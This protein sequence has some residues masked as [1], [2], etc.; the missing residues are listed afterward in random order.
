L[1]KAIKKLPIPKAVMLGNHDHGHDG[2]GIL[3]KA[4][5]NLL[6]ELNCAWQFQKWQNPDFS[7]V[8]AR[9]CSSGGG[10]YISREVQ[11]VF[12]PISL[13]QS[14]DRIVSSAREVSKILPFII[15]A[16]SGPA[17]LG[18]DSSSPCGR[19][20]KS[21]AIDWG[22]KDL[23]IAIDH[24]RKIKV[25]DL[26]VFGHTHHQL[27]R[28]QGK[29]VTFLKDIW[30]TAYLNAACVPRRGTTLKGESLCHFSWVEFKFNKLTHVSHRWYRKNSSLAYQEILLDD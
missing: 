1:V 22:D 21:P 23:S 4:Q 25:P 17:G 24:I 30:G 10:F 26:V 14:V 16:H 20:W 3:L 27:K 13:E 29:R 19:D 15:L 18:S 28:G 8:G 11:A 6:G 2:S 9:P 12:G 5:L 7:L